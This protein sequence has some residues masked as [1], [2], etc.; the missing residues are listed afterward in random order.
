VC[1]RLSAELSNASVRSMLNRLVAKGILKRTLSGN[2]FIYL[3]ALTCTDSGALALKR[4]AED[5]F[6]GSIERAAATM[7][8]ALNA[9]Q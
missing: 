7:L 1:E 2:A 5:H 9:G 4:F 8:S 3:P 6:A